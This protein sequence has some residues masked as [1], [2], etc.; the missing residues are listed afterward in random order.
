MSVFFGPA[1]AMIGVSTGNSPEAMQ[2]RAEV[3][4][5]FT[6]WVGVSSII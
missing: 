1:C 6:F 2:A 3:A 5:I 4:P